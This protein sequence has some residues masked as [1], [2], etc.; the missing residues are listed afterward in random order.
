MK[1]LYTKQDDSYLMDNFKKV[2]TDEMALYLNR[3]KASVCQRLHIIRD[4]GMI[5]FKGHKGEKLTIGL[6]E[7]SLAS[8]GQRNKESMVVIKENIKNGLCIDLMVGNKREKCLVSYTN[9]SYFSVKRKNYIESFKYSELLQGTITI[10][11]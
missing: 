3:S 9:E 5:G 1:M 8:Q 11:V 7:I 4:K 2:T 6:K 10:L